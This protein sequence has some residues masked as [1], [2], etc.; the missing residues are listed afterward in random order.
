MRLPSRRARPV[1]MISPHRLT[2]LATL[3]HML[4]F[5]PARSRRY[6]LQGGA[7]ST[8]P[9]WSK[10]QPQRPI[11]LNPA[12]PFD[13]SR[14][15]PRTATCLHTARNS[16]HAPC[17]RHPTGKNRPTSKWSARD[18]QGCH[19]L[20]LGPR[21]RRLRAFA[22]PEKRPLGRHGARPLPKKARTH[23]KIEWPM[24]GGL[25]IENRIINNVCVSVLCS[26]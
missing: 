26:F 13:S 24:L 17:V 15:R 5:P 19:F 22:R 18:D 6:R 11:A 12:P 2:R 10:V 16:L 7:R 21:L 3:R 1:G 23:S 8:S 20:C 25:W 9:T 4:T 14:H